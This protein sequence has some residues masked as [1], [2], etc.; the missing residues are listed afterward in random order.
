MKINGI[1]INIFKYKI[2]IINQYNLVIDVTYKPEDKEKYDKLFS[3]GIEDIV[4]LLKDSIIIRVNT[5]SKMYDSV[6]L[7]IN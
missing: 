7:V 5:E 4:D 6:Y 2:F 1:L 3:R